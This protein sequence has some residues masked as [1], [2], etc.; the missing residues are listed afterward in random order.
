MGEVAK[1]VCRIVRIEDDVLWI[2]NAD[3]DGLGEL[4]RNGKKI[5]DDVKSILASKYYNG[6]FCYNEDQD[7]S[8]V[9]GGKTS[10]VCREVERVIIGNENS[11]LVLYDYDKGEGTL[12]YYNGKDVIKIGDDV[13]GMAR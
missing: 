2:G 11:V 9:K 12:G 13:K 6:I 5:A 1:D 10:D 3:D 4:F 8:V 7:L